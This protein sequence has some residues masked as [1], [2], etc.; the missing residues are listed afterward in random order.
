M[1]TPHINYKGRTIIYCADLVPSRWHL[2][3]PFV[4]A[5]DT[6]P[7]LTLDEKEKVLPEAAAGDYLL[8]LEHDPTVEMI[9]LQATDKGVR[10]KEQ[11][12]L[13]DL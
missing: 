3:I 12:R 8:Y 7:L 6:R 2:P 13:Q 5:Y 10:E 1:I 9:S 4:M 11:L